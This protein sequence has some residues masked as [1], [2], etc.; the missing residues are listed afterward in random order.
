M[1][2]I[3]CG[4][5]E[6]KQG[7]LSLPS[8]MHRTQRFHTVYVL[9][10]LIWFHWT[11]ELAPSHNVCMT[12]PPCP[13]KSH[14]HTVMDADA[15]LLDTVSN[16]LCLCPASWQHSPWHKTHQRPE[17][18]ETRERQQSNKYRIHNN[19]KILWVTLFIF[20]K[21][22][23]NSWINCKLDPLVLYN[24]LLLLRQPSHVDTV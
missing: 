23:S 13:G 9:C 6:A 18:P 10:P 19:Q 22:R 4:W 14:T 12:T 3:I 17:T 11:L 5:Q 20:T 24:Y 21:T 8:V 16:S 2:L 1:L 15:A 7:L